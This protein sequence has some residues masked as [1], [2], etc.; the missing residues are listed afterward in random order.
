[1]YK[2]KN[3][4]SFLY[5]PFVF[6]KPWLRE[7]FKCLLKLK[8]RKFLCDSWNKTTSIRSAVLV[9][10]DELFLVKIS[11]IQVGNVKQLIF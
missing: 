9:A 10:L 2:D 4:W 8:Q 1:M 7:C 5:L 6:L 11:R 3:S